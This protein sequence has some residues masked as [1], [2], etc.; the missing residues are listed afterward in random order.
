MENESETTYVGVVVVNTGD[1]VVAWVG[2]DEKA[3][4]AAVFADIEQ[5]RQDFLKD[6]PEGEWGEPIEVGDWKTLYD[7]WEYRLIYVC[8]Q[9]V[10]SKEA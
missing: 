1:E 7:T 3:A 9:P 6:E 4:I 5:M 10:A 8:T 2:E